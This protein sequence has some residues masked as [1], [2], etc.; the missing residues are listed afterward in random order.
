MN[1]LGGEPEAAAARPGSVEELLRR[2]QML[3]SET[4]V[5]QVRACFQFEISTADGQQHQYYLDL[6][7]GEEW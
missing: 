5:Q 6:S 1:E 4:L 2:V 3:L 7:Q